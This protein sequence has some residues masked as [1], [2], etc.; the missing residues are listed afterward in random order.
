MKHLKQKIQQILKER[1]SINITNPLTF[2]EKEEL[3]ESAILDFNKD[4]QY[5]PSDLYIIFTDIFNEISGIFM[6]NQMIY[7]FNDKNYIEYKYDLYINIHF[8]KKLK[9]YSIC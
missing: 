3:I 7:I 4:G 5:S 2:T 1:G 6:E 8:N 9:E